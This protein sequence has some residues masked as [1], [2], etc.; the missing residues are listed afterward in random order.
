[1]S[2]QIREQVSAFLDGELPGS[3]TELLLKRLTRD[4]EL[5]ESFGRYTLIGE[6]LRVTTRSHLTRGF[7]SRV[8]RTI[9]GEPAVPVSS[10]PERRATAW[11]RPLAGGALAAGVAVVAVVALQQR[12]DT[13]TVR[14]A[15]NVVPRMVPSAAKSSEAISYTVPAALNQAPSTLPSARL[16]SYVFA[17]SRY[18]SPLGPHNLLSDLVADGDDALPTLGGPGLPKASA[19]EPAIAP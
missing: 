13:P 15:N 14:A 9:D 6:A 1:M 7:S 17:H 18:S 12:A 5:R 11:W 19:P 8:N 16:T 4:G 3:E 10:A 2:E